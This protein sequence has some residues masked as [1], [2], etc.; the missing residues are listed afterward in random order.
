[1]IKCLKRLALTPSVFLF[2]AATTN[3]ELCNRFGKY[4]EKARHDNSH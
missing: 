4:H 2:V 1:M 3:T